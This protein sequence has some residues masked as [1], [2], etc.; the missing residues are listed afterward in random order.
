MATVIERE[1]PVAYDNSGGWVA[2]VL[3]LIAVVLFGLFIW[4]GLVRREPAPVQ[5]NPGVNLQVDVPQGGGAQTPSGGSG[6]QP[7]PQY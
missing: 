5:Q 2:A 7:S 3:V 1:R 6:G 4:P